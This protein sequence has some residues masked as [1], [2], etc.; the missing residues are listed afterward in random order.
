M[1]EKK[2][3]VVI[4]GAVVIGLLM[5][6]GWILSILGDSLRLVTGVGV[7]TWGKWLIFGLGALVVFSFAKN[8]LRR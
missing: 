3:R 6:F 4:Y 1:P 8:R 7:P 2:Y 5:L